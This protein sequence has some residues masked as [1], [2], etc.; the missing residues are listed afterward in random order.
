MMLDRRDNKQPDR[1][2]AEPCESEPL[3]WRFIRRYVSDRHSSRDTLKYILGEGAL[4]AL[5]GSLA[6]IGT[7]IG[8]LEQI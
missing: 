7:D 6:G 4:S 5:G 1:D 8:K 3:L 2:N